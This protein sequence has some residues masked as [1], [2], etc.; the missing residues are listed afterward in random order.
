[1]FASSVFFFRVVSVCFISL[2]NEEGN[3]SFLLCVCSSRTNSSVIRFLCLCERELGEG[4]GGCLHQD[5]LLFFLYPT[6]LPSVS[7]CSDFCHLKDLSVCLCVLVCQLV[8]QVLSSGVTV[9]CA[10]AC[11]TSPDQWVIQISLSFTQVFWYH[12]V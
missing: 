8:T 12:K 1:M 3:F 9:C 10:E 5:F 2:V 7:V 11:I 4:K 6:V